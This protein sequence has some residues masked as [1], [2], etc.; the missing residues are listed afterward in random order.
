MLNQTEQTNPNQNN[1][2]D[3]LFDHLNENYKELIKKTEILK[4]LGGFEEGEIGGEDTEEYPTK[5]TKKTEQIQCQPNEEIE[6]DE[7]ISRLFKSSVS[8]NVSP[9]SSPSRNQALIISKKLS[10][11]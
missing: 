6:I 11:N 4:M 5:D 7:L 3:V 10:R 9:I 2:N 8:A 1:N